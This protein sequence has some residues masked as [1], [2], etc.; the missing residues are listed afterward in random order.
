[1]GRVAY[2][3]IGRTIVAV[4]VPSGR[5]RRRTYSKD[6]LSRRDWNWLSRCSGTVGARVSTIC[7]STVRGAVACAMDG[8]STMGVS[9]NRRRVD[10][11]PTAEA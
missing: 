1:M 7:W 9:T 6:A 4:V 11:A 2:A 5:L 8:K 3:V 10:S